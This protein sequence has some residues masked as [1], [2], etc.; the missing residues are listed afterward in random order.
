MTTKT[1]SPYTITSEMVDDILT[2]AM[3]GGSDYWTAKVEVI[4]TVPETVTST[5]FPG[6]EPFASEM[7]T[8]GFRLR[9]VEDGGDE[10]VVHTLTLA[11]MKRGIR[12][13]AAHFEVTPL[14]FYE[15]HDASDA[16][17]AV[18]YALLGEVVYG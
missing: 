17:L 18:Q 12:K 10:N 6:E 2:A 13:A 5:L 4:G 7:L 9:W 15:N 3:E 8:K 11:K 16:D 14:A 1:A